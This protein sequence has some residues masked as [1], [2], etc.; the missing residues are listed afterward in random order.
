MSNIIEELSSVGPASVHEIRF[1]AREWCGSAET[2]RLKE[3]RAATR[4][5]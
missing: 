3:R 4:R 5:E 2:L 1:A